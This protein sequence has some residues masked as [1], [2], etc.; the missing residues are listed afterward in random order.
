M[1][2]AKGKELL[3]LIYKPCFAEMLAVRKVTEWVPGLA[4]LLPI[5]VGEDEG[6]RYC[7]QGECAVRRTCGEMVQQGEE[8][9]EY[10]QEESLTEKS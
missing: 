10:R 8:Q 5:K 9:C 1:I 3:D 4:E 7:M 6:L 2:L